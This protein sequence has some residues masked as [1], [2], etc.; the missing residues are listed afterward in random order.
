MNALL[1]RE[2]NITFKAETDI[3]SLE[4]NSYFMSS[5]KFNSEGEGKVLKINDFFA[6]GITTF[7][8]NK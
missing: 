2:K 3:N 1:D 5:I 8:V 4:I 6:K 7:Q